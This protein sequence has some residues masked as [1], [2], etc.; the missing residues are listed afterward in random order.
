M[1]KKDTADIMLVGDCQVIA[2]VENEGCRKADTCFVFKKL[3][4]LSWLVAGNVL[5]MTVSMFREPVSIDKTVSTELVCNGSTSVFTISV[6]GN[7]FTVMCG[8]R[9]GSPTILSTERTFRI[10]HTTPLDAEHTIVK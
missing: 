2:E 4:V 7:D 5:M 3:K 6:V 10:E 8:K 9:R 1:E